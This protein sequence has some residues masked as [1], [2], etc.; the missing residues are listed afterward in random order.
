MSDKY[1]MAGQIKLINSTQTFDSGFTKR[2]FVVTSEDDKYPQDVKFEVVKD[3][4]DKL[5]DYNV[6]DNVT[7]SFNIRGNEYNDKYYVNLQ[8]WRMEQQA[9]TQSVAEAKVEAGQDEPV[10]VE[11]DS[12]SELPF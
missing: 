9:G 4:C 7:V 6:G 10:S 3:G 8:C 11:G 1:E 12:S 2:E 5:D